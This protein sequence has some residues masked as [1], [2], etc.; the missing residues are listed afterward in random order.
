MI[1]LDQLT[2][3]GQHQNPPSG[4]AGQFGDDQRLAAAGGQHHHR[5]LIGLTKVTNDAFHRITL[6]GPQ[7]WPDGGGRRRWREPG[8]GLGHDDAF[9]LQGSA[10]IDPG[11]I[12]VHSAPVA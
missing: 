6:I 2:H 5:G 12:S 1:L 3:V 11:H 9:T 8:L 7:L 10:N 4:Q